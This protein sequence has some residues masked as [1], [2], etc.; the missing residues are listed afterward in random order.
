VR[1]LTAV[2]A[3]SSGDTDKVSDLIDG[4]EKAKVVLLDR[5]RI[6]SSPLSSSHGRGQ[7]A[8]DEPSKH[9]VGA[10]GEGPPAGTAAESQGLS[11]GSESEPEPVGFSEFDLEKEAEPRKAIIEE[12]AAMPGLPTGHS[13]SAIAGAVKTAKKLNKLRRATPTGLLKADVQDI[14]ADLDR[15]M[16]TGQELRDV[17]AAL[18]APATGRAGPAETDGLAGLAAELRQACGTLL[19]SLKRGKTLTH[20]SHSRM[21]AACEAS[22]R[23]SQEASK[24][25]E[26]WG[27]DEPG[28]ALVRRLGGLGADVQVLTGMVSSVVAAHEPSVR[29]MS[30]VRSNL[31]SIHTGAQAGQEISVLNNYFGIGLDAKIAF[32][33]D[34]L[35]REHPEKC[36][37]RMKNQMWYGYL[38]VKQTLVNSYK[39]LHK[40]ITIEADGVVLKLPKWVVPLWLSCPY[41]CLGAPTS[42]RYVCVPGLTQPLAVLCVGCDA[43]RACAGARA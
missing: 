33:F 21:M 3:A 26:A 20:D 36:R 13:Q 30:R 29:A 16:R 17:A 34:T 12:E 37:S 39:N 18:A 42:A 40:R 25:A 27:A 9:T 41:V 19:V 24:V 38:G 23:L 2:A 1:W 14:H 32:D 7:Q 43:C 15:V 6:T 5:W 31:D 8:A 35:R 28:P 22:S 4:V 11:S 10:E